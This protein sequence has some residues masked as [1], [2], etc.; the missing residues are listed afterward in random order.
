[1]SMG[2]SILIFVV[3][4]SVII[5]FVYYSIGGQGGG[6]T[7]LK[8]GAD[9]YSGGATAAA[10]NIGNIASAAGAPP[11]YT[12][13]QSPVSNIPGFGQ[14]PSPSLFPSSSWLQ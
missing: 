7:V 11:A 12:P 13:I 1:M 10:R 14:I 9:F 2:G 8:M 6:Q 5:Y 4:A 3:L